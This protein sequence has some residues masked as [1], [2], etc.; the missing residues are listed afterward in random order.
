M[1]STAIPQSSISAAFAT[2]PRCG[3]TMLEGEGVHL[4]GEA[5]GGVFGQHDRITV[6]MRGAGGRLHAHVGG[7]AAGITTVVTPRRRSCRSRSVP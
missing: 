3:K 6:L 4:G 1:S 7:D 5:R 2:R